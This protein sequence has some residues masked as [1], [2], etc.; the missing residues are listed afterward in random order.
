[1]DSTQP[2]LLLKRAENLLTSTGQP[3]FKGLEST[4][5]D[6]PLSESPVSLRRSLNASIRRKFEVVKDAAGLGRS[7]TLGSR[8]A[9]G[10][11]RAGRLGR[12]VRSFSDSRSESPFAKGEIFENT[13]VVESDVPVPM[14][15]LQGTPMTKITERGRSNAVFRVDPDLGQIIWES[16]K[17]RI[18]TQYFPFHS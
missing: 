15:L 8:N 2:S 17:H 1:M 9:V 18:S 7:L 4:D 11:S 3:A 12:H 10:G 6:V 16:R 14:L 5:D 13:A